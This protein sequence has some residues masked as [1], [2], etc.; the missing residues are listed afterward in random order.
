MCDELLEK[1][2]KCSEEENSEE[3]DYSPLRST[4]RYVK[5]SFVVLLGILSFYAIFMLPVSEKTLARMEMKE[6]L[7][8][9]ASAASMNTVFKGSTIN[10][11]M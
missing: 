8:I 7:E 10:P 5:L 1:T 6:K 4:D 2:S 9:Q 3:T 11:L